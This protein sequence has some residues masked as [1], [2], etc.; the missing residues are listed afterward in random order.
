MSYDLT[1]AVIL[2]AKELEIF[3]VPGVSP[4]PPLKW[5]L[6]GWVLNM[7]FVVLITEGLKFSVQ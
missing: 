3:M 5:I 7:L 4:S 6:R 2:E 1:A